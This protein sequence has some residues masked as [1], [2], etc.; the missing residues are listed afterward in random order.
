MDAATLAK[1]TE[2]FFTTKGVGKGTG[3]GLSMVHGLAEQSGGF[4]ARTS[5]RGAGPTAEIWL[6]VADSEAD[7][8]PAATPAATAIES[9]PLR[10]LTVDDDALVLMNTVAM[11]EELGHEV[12]SAYSGA[13]ALQMLEAAPFDLLI[14]DQGMPKMTGTELAEAAGARWPEMPIIVATGY[15]ELSDKARALPR[16]TKPFSQRDLAAAI[17]GSV[18]AGA[19]RLAGT[20]A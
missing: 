6:P 8:R 16:L 5:R 12:E 15:A 10:V 4:L 13:E 20:A 1:A 11:L 17:A 14:T 3:L 18:G 7:A 19:K 9:K 2:P